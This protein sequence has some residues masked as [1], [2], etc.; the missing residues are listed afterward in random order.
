MSAAD[1]LVRGFVAFGDREAVIWNGRSTTY[2]WLAAAVDSAREDIRRR[3]IESG[4]IVGLEADFSPASVA[5]LLALI[6]HD[7]IVVPLPSEQDQSNNDKL[8]IAQV[9]HLLVVRDSEEIVH[10]ARP[11][12]PGHAFYERLRELRAPGLVLFTSGTSGV[13]KA[14]VHNLALLLD[15]FRA[16]RTAQRTINFLLFDHIGGLNTLFH[17]LANGGVV[18]TVRD[19]S[20][21]AV[22]SLIAQHPVEVLPTSP[23]FLNLL[24][25][26]E[27]YQRHDL[28]SLKVIS[29]GTEPMP[30]STLDRL[31]ELFPGI[32]LKQTY[33]LNELGIL[34]SRSRDSASLW[35]QV[36]GEGYEIRVVDG[37]LQIKASSAMLGYLN[38]PSPFT[39]D[40][41]FVTGDAVEEAGGYLRVLGR[42]SEQINIGGEKVYP[43]EVEE[44]IRQLANVAEVVVYGEKNQIMGSIVC[45]KINLIEPE[46]AAGCVARIKRE[47]RLRLA[48]AKVPV[49]IKIETAPLYGRRLKVVRR[50]E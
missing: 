35:M 30:Q 47:C 26:S 16:A 39:D 13:P 33:G 21:D 42:R 31:V 37:I 36:G 8:D 50:H 12:P 4:D 5:L 25:I 45:A 43:A 10:T 2:S 41:Y 46:D 32:A 18:V 38:A 15:K 44:V 28:S 1:F 27:A 6:E 9:R 19:R 29:Y 23:T 49:K 34:R 22:C 24:L 48:S 40:G 17:T 14:T 11:A 3:K 7:C 20:P